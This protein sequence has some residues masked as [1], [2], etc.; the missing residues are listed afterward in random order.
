MAAAK[1]NQDW[2]N[3]INSLAAQAPYIEDL[4]QPLHVTDNYNGQQSGNGGVHSRYE[5]SMVNRHLADLTF[6]PAT[7]TYI[8]NI[9]ESVF[10]G[11]DVT[12]PHVAEIMAADT[13]AHAATGSTSS[14]AY[15]DSLWGQTGGFTKQQFQDVSEA[16]ADGWYT[17]WVNAGSPIPNLGLAGDYNGD[18]LID[19]ADYTVW[20][21]AMANG[22]SSLINDFAPGAVNTTDYDY[23]RSTSGLQSAADQAPQLH[24]SPHR[25]YCWQQRLFCA[26]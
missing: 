8:P 2:L 20:R 16:V 6:A 26:N 13:A 23:W 10:D 7:A 12:Y 25:G 9:L 14:T 21:D 1:T 17:S 19:A 15:Y 11:I 5:T 4:H 22:S 18:N 3:M 24:L